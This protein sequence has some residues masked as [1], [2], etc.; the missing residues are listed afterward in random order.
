M[1]W[2]MKDQKEDGEKTLSAEMS[3]G[4]IPTFDPVRAEQG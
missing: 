1:W 4:R 2:V 3:S